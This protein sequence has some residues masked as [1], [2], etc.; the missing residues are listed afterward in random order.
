MTLSLKE[1]FHH[2]EMM[3]LAALCGTMTSKYEA[4]FGKE[5]FSLPWALQKILVHSRSP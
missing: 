3:G 4:F 5:T 2:L 1:G